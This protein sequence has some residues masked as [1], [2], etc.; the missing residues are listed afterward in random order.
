M[1]LKAKTPGKGVPIAEGS[2]QKLYWN[3]EFTNYAICNIDKCNTI[4]SFPKSAT[5]GVYTHIDSHSSTRKNRKRPKISERPFEELSVKQK[6]SLVIALKLIGQNKIS[7]FKATSDGMISTYQAVLF[8]A[9]L[10]IDE[11]ELVESRRQIM[12]TVN[13]YAEKV[14]QTIKEEIAGRSV[15]FI[16]DD[17]RSQTGNKEAIRAITACFVKDN[18]LVRRF[19]HLEYIEDKDGKS[20]ADS[21]R[22]VADHYGITDYQIAA[23]GA[24]ANITAANL[25]RLLQHSC[26]THGVHL[27]VENGFKK[28]KEKYPGFNQFYKVF[29]NFISKS[30]R[31]HLNSK[32]GKVEGFI[33]IPTLS[34]T[35]WLSR[36]DCV[37][38]II[39]NWKILQDN[40]SL[41]GLNDAQWEYFDNLKLFQELFELIETA[42][43]CLQIFEVQQQTTSHIVIPTLSKWLHKLFLFTMNGNN[44]HFGRL[45]AQE[46]IDQIDLYSF[47]NVGSTV[48][49][50]LHSTHI[51]QSALHPEY[52]LLDTTRAKIESDTVAIGGESQVLSAN[53]SIELRFN[54]IYD[55]LWKNLKESYERLYL[56]QNNN[57]NAENSDS[58]DSDFDFS[59]LGSLSQEQRNIIKT[60]LK[61]KSD[62][63][64]YFPLKTE[65]KKFKSFIKEFKNWKENLN[66]EGQ[67]TPLIRQYNL[68]KINR[69]DIHILFWT[70][71]DVKLTFPILHSIVMH[72]I[73][74]PASSAAVESLFSH[75]TEVKNF[76][77]S[78]LSDKNLN[79]ILTLFY[80]DLYMKDSVTDFFKS[81]VNK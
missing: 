39:R 53:E 32:L 67:Y 76:K 26:W 12:R 14:R 48:K 36:R 68:M 55:R 41:I 18:I 74:V 42:T 33:K 63:K 19:L 57:Q 28:T 43:S 80:S 11:S 51:I 56:K 29:E 72:T 15:T 24:S 66:G 13:C 71:K 81:N 17:T 10:D 78:L 49:P 44:S 65:F 27:I 62:D 77:R 60:H 69:K 40:K 73:H 4:I 54:R 61:K 75:V 16:H 8:A 38:A 9:G 3:D 50:R 59:S 5:R 34:K 23:D 37:N 6:M 1:T 22:K 58:S 52:H 46:L 25:L 20:I 64:L 70:M 79:D 7:A 21:I 30:A 2:I 31:R 47:G 35:R 45:L